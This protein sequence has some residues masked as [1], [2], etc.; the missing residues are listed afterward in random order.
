M[1][2]IQFRKLHR[3]DYAEARTILSDMYRL[4]LFAG[5]SPT[6]RHLQGYIFHKIL[7][8]QNYNEVAVVDGHLGGLLCAK[9]GPKGRLAK[10][11]HCCLLYTS[12]PARTISRR[13]AWAANTASNPSSAIIAVASA[14]AYTKE[15]AG[16]W[17]V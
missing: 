12:T 13:R 17:G 7:M 3:S 9:I 6:I 2:T 16:V 14:T 4:Q 5:S 8:N 11:P 10:L 15:T 1:S